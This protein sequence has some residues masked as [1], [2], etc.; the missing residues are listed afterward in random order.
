MMTGSIGE[1]CE[2]M[3]NR[4]DRKF[5]LIQS[6]RHR[7]LTIKQRNLRLGGGICVPST[8]SSEKVQ[9]FANEILSQADLL[10]TKDYDQSMFCSTNDAKDFRTI[11]IIAM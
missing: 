5:K 2:L 11:D 3:H 10:V 4:I 6:I 9:S 1:R 7:G 8:C